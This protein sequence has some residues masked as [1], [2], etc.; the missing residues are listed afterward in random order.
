MLRLR[1]IMT[2][3]VLTVSPELTLRHACELLVRHHLGGAPVTRGGTLVGVLSS[4]D[5]LDFQAWPPARL[6]ERDGGVDPVEL[7]DTLPEGD[8]GGASC[9]WSYWADDAV[10]L[11]ERLASEEL[12]EPD[13]LDENTVD[14][15]MTR[16]VLSLPGSATVQEGAAFMTR[17]GIHRVIIEEEGKLVGIVTTSDV[18]RVVGERGLGSRGH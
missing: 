18:T 7:V 15:A 10:D 3:E 2:T 12:A 4:T 9:F 6:A 11:V 1:D 16:E 8:D 17:H 13:V 5:L 14:S